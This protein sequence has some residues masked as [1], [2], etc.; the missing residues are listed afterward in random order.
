[1]PPH[2][3]DAEL[4]Q[5]PVPSYGVKS[6]L[7]ADDGGMLWSIPDLEHALTGITEDRFMTWMQ[8]SLDIFTQIL[9]YVAYH[10]PYMVL[11]ECNSFPTEKKTTSFR[12]RFQVSNGGR[13]IGSTKLAKNL[14]SHAI[15]SRTSDDVNF[16]NLPFE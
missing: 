10:S 11:Y 4:I 5:L 9:Q 7:G 3:V 1:M 16:P 14:F 8:L 13:N 2:I 12:G 6:C 15:E